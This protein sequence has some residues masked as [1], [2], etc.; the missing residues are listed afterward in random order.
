MRT[1]KVPK[2]DM[3]LVLIERCSNFVSYE[4]PPGIYELRNIITV[5]GS[6]GGLQGKLQTENVD[7]IKE[8]KVNIAKITLGF[9]ENSFLN[10]VLCFIPFCDFKPNFV[11]F[12]QES[13]NYN[14]I[15]FKR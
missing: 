3:K 13:E 6:F 4:L 12:S 7:I 9:D 2:D 5:I 15:S 14:Y 8:I 11:F 1:E 10:T